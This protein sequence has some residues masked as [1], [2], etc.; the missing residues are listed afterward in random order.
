LQPQW[1]AIYFPLF[2]YREDSDL[3]RYLWIFDVEIKVWKSE[4][5]HLWLWLS[6]I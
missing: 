4:N 3:A 6:S 5:Q 1:F 2:V